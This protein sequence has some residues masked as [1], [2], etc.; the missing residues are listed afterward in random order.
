[1]EWDYATIKMLQDSLDLSYHQ[2]R[3]VFHGY[4]ARGVKYPGLLFKCPAV[5]YVD[6]VVPE[7]TEA[8]TVRK[9][10]QRFLFNYEVYRG[11]INS[12]SVVLDDDDDDGSSG[13]VADD[14]VGV[15]DGSEFATWHGDNTVGVPSANPDLSGDIQ[16]SSD[17]CEF[18]D[19]QN[20]TW[21]SFSGAQRGHLSGDDGSGC[22]I[23]EMS[24]II[25][26]NSVYSRLYDYRGDLRGVCDGTLRVYESAMLPTGIF[27]GGCAGSLDL[28]FNNV[29]G[30]YDAGSGG[31]SGLFS[32]GTV[33][34]DGLPG[35][36]SLAEGYGGGSSNQDEEYK[37]FRFKS[38]VQDRNSVIP[39]P[40]LF[41]SGD[42]SRVYKDLGACHICGKRRVRF[43]CEELSVNV[44][45]LCMVRI[46]K[47][48]GWFLGR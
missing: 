44:C 26:D 2:V 29:A 16:D 31:L 6:T 47:D 14:E 48:K 24:A 12:C 17:I 42:F 27:S 38:S 9:R 8:G 4:S 20:T 36:L 7:D 32:G 23:S 25:Y 33:C 30:S 1:M 34:C 39:L 10:E 11:W 19:G 3:R 21:H 37:R 13:S 28:S 5:S 18:S 22:C 45:D 15:P 41:K 43:R 46:M 35:S 40:G